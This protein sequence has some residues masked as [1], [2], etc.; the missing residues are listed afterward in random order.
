MIS[1]DKITDL[2]CITDEFCKEFENFEKT[3]LLEI[4]PRKSP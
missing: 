3:I 4:N 1:F 2:F